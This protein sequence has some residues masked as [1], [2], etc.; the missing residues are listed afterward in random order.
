M[1][2]IEVWMVESLKQMDRLKSLDH[3][4]MESKK[5]SRTR[6]N[7]LKG[8]FKE[9]ASIVKCMSLGQMGEMILT[10]VRKHIRILR[11]ELK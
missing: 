4:A 1:I 8:V 10:R 6:I 2:R 7:S 5:G 9:Q 11:L 3:W